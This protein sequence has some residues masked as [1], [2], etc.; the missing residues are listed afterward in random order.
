MCS[1]FS[2][3]Q[4]INFSR[5]KPEGVKKV[6]EYGTKHLEFCIE[7]YEMQIEMGLYFL[8][9]HPLGAASWGNEKMKELMRIP[10]VIKVAGDMCQFGMYQEVEG[11]GTVIYF[12]GYECKDTESG[13]E[14]R[15]R[16]YWEIYI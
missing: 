4:N 3:L 6:V 8:H 16:A 5:M 10:G 2:Q 7:L 12:R 1:A 14:E 11:K 9:E 15:K 13:G